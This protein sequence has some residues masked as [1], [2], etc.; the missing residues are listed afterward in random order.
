MNFTG[1]YDATAALSDAAQT[2]MYL[3]DKGLRETAGELYNLSNLLLGSLSD[4]A[5]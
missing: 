2:N 3:A 4:D 5:I 1:L